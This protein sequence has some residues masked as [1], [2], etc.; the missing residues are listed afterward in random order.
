MW[1]VCVDAALFVQPQPALLV[2]T[3][4]TPEVCAHSQLLPEN[5]F[6]DA[7][8]LGW[9]VGASLSFTS[10][11]AKPSLTLE[12]GVPLVGF[13]DLEAGSHQGGR[14]AP[15]PKQRPDAEATAGR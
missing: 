6:R 15:A 10:Q 14:V 11:S 13:T 5:K 8:L 7:E 2:F 1:V 12:A 4:Q 9:Q 3:P